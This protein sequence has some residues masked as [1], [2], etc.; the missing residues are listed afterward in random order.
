MNS[1]ILMYVCVSCAVALAVVWFL[2]ALNEKGVNPFYE[3]FG[4]FRNQSL[5]GLLLIPI[6]V[7]KAICFGSNKAPT[8]DVTGAGSEVTNG[9]PGEV[10]SPTN[11]PPPLTMAWPG[12]LTPDPWF[13]SGFTPDELAVGY[14]LWRTGTNE[15]WSFDPM[16]EAKVI[17]DWRLR[18]AADD[19]AVC[20]TTNLGPVVMTTDGRLVTTN[21]VFTVD[22]PVSLLKR[23]ENLF[24]VEMVDSR[25]VQGVRLVDFRLD[26][27]Y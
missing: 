17:E 27:N 3:I 13:D 21:G 24:E 19:W 15:V 5:L 20:A 2:A 11:L 9:V 26:V 18:G 6:L 10:S 25:R 1:T 16:P 22:V 4:R 14:A 8:N 7:L 23:G 12:P